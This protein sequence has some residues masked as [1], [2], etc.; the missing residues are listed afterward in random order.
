MNILRGFLKGINAWMVTITNPINAV[1]VREHLNQDSVAD[2]TYYHNFYM[3]GFN[4]AYI[5]LVAD[6]STVLTIE[7]TNFDDAS[8]VKDV[9]STVMS[10]ATV[11]GGNDSGLFVGSPYM[12]RIKAVV[13][14][15]GGSAAYDVLTKRYFE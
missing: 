2:G 3:D 8:V 12:L 1:R 9:T 4:R 7:T 5:Q 6:A 10:G 14:G 11:T 13:S 15:G